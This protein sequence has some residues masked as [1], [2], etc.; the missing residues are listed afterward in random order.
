MR[1]LVIL[2]ITLFLPSE[3]LCF[4][5]IN[6]EEPSLNAFFDPGYSE[7]TKKAEALRFESSLNMSLDPRIAKLASNVAMLLR[8]SQ[9][10]CAIVVMGFEATG[11]EWCSSQLADHQMTDRFFS[12]F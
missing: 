5:D 6:T 12:Q 7:Q 9:W 2:S 11:M 10:V 3:I 1:L 4:P 8:L